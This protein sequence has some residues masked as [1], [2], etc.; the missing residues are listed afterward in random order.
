MKFKSAIC[1]I[2]ITFLMI[3]VCRLV[4][5]D[6]KNDGKNDKGTP[7]SAPSAI[8]S[9]SK[10]NKTESANDKND[11]QKP[12][13][14]RIANALHEQPNGIECVYRLKVGNLAGMAFK[15]IEVHYKI[16]TVKD[17]QKAIEHPQK[18]DPPNKDNDPTE[19]IIPTPP[20]KYQV[21]CEFVGLPA[22]S[23]FNSVSMMDEDGNLVSE[24]LTTERTK[25][26]TKI[27][28]VKVKF[29][30]I[31]QKLVWSRDELKKGVPKEGRPKECMIGSEDLI[32]TLLQLPVWI[33][34]QKPVAPKVQTPFRL[35]VKG[36]PIPM[37]MQVDRNL[38]ENGSLMVIC[39]K[40]EN[41]RMMGIRDRSKFKLRFTEKEYIKAFSWPAEIEMVFGDNSLQLIQKNLE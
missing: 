3:G 11:G 15:D 8:A 12:L 18:N 1:L 17:K 2:I 29:L 19:K 4:A 14:S 22:G 24:I 37:I 41:G 20:A 21:S 5:D 25:E 23:I 32:T 33:S 36:E 30:G 9:E 27:S 26:T 35:L 10:E 39:E 38:V 6:G 7:K 16:S 34:A 31:S 13:Q 28:K 40:V